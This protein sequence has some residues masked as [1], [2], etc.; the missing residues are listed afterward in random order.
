MLARTAASSSKVGAMS[1]CLS[2]GIA[3][4]FQCGGSAQTDD[5][6]TVAAF[7]EDDDMKAVAD[8]AGRDE[9]R[10][11]VAVIEELDGGMPFEGFDGGEIRAVFGLESL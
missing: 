11:S 8:V 1:V 4:S 3:F 5:A 9:T 2:F 10:L 7:D 6:K